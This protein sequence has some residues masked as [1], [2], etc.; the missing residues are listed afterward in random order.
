M[1]NPVINERALLILK[2]IIKRYIRDGQP[3]GSK[4]IAEDTSP[5]MALSSATIRNIMADLENAGYLRSPHTSAGRIPTVQ[6]YRLFVDTLITAQPLPDYE[7]RQLKEKLRPNAE[8]SALV[9]TASS[10]LSNMTK[11]AGLVTLP[12][13]ERATLRQIEF[14]PLAPDRD[15]VLTILVFNDLEIQNRV[16]YTDRPYAPAELETAG[17]YLTQ[18]FAGKGLMEIR[19]ALVNAMA[20]DRDSM[21]SI[22][23]NVMNIAGK[24]F[25]EESEEDYVLAGQSNLI[26]LAEEAGL[27]RLQSLF[28]A[29]SHKRDILH[30]FDQCLKTDGVQIF[31][32]QESGYEVFDSCSIV[33]KAYSVEGN[34]VGVL[35]VIGP[36]RMAYDRVI[37]AVDI[38]AKLLSAALSE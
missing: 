29:L 14:L 19:Q 9:E 18:T 15:R 17:N 37:S 2:A 28:E 5:E 22:M 8:T 3:V 38:T 32:G 33:T 21:R 26:G 24:V 20:T 7:I 12:K 23:Q 36:T 13:R 6:G 1:E 27:N 31:I 4:A 34:V 10:W 11:L 35:G 30:L 16:I 25:T